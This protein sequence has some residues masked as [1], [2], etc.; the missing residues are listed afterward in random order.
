M[1]LSFQRFDW[2]ERRPVATPLALLLASAGAAQ[3]ASPTARLAPVAHGQAGS[4][5]LRP[6]F[7]RAPGAAFHAPMAAALT[8]WQYL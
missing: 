8:H 7:A 4:L 2:Q 6:A 1:D 3:A 5:T